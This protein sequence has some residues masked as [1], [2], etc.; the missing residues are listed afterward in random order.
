MFGIDI[1]ICKE[2]LQKLPL[3]VIIPQKPPAE[4]RI[5]LKTDFFHF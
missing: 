5:H 3:T 2:G 4:L 1:Q